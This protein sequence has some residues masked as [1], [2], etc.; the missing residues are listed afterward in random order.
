MKFFIDT[1]NIDEIKKAASYGFLDGV[2]T[3]PSLMAKE[4]ISDQDGRIK[5]ICALTSGPVSAEVLST[6]PETMLAEARHLASL[7]TNVVI[8]LPLTM[9][10]LKT[11][12]ILANEDIH[13]NVTLVFS[14]LQALLAAKAGAAYISPFVGRLDD[15]GVDGLGIVEDIQTIY[16]NYGYETE[17]IVASIRN[18]QH[19]LRAA[20]LGADISTI[21]FSVIN[22]LASHPMTQQG[23]ATF[24]ADHA[25]A[26]EIKT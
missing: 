12:K 23:L 22:Q 6:E 13:V 17:I 21:P 3:N 8:K 19:V 9:T 10:G 15:T 5:A 4:G 25:R 16:S 20:L 18:P 1:A 24:L 7:A 14:A 2:T 11:T 26:K